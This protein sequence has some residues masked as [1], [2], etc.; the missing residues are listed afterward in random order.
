MTNRRFL[1][2]VLPPFFSAF[3]DNFLKN[4]WLLFILFAP[5]TSIETR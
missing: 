1:G 2:A 5:G 3:N 4:S